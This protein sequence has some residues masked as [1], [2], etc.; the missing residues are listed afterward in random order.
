MRLQHNEPSNTR[1]FIG[2]FDPNDAAGI[3][4]VLDPD[5]IAFVPIEPVAAAGRNSVGLGQSCW[6][7]G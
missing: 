6:R 7:S 5:Q 1:A 2:E 3:R 4:H